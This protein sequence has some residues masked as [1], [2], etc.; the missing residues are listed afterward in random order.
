M[1]RKSTKKKK[2]ATKATKK[3][4]KKTK[5]AGLFKKLFK[6]AVVFG[7]WCAI[8]VIALV[9]WYGSEL[10]DLIKSPHFERRASIEIRGQ[11]DDLLLRY[12]EIMGASVRVEDLPSHMIY[13]LIAVEDRR[14]YL[15]HGVDPIG[16]ARAMARNLISGRI[17][18]GGSTLTQQLAK[19]LFLTHERT[20][21]RK[22]QE[23]MLAIWL[24]REFTKDEILTAYFNRVY[25]GSG[26]YGISAAARIYFDKEPKDLTLYQSALIAGLLKAPSRYSP[27]ANPELAKKRTRVVLSAMKDAGFLTETAMID[28]N[29][30]NVHI[31]TKTISSNNMRYATDWILSEAQALI[32]KTDRDLVIT[33]TLSKNIQKQA[34]ESLHNEMERIQDR[35]VT[36]GA[37][38]VTAYNGAVLAMVGGS[39]Y[40]KSQYNR[41]TQSR[42]PPGSAF[43]PVVYLTALQKGYDPDDKIEDSPITDGSYKPSNFDD[44]YLGEVTLN[45]ALS[46]SLNTAA[47]KLAN[48]VGIGNIIKTA[49]TLGIQTKLNRDLSLALG[50][51]GIPMTEMVAAYATIANDGR[52]SPPYIITTIQDEQGEIL[53]S[54]KS[55]ETGK[56][57]VKKKNARDLSRMME[58]TISIGTG[59]NAA[60]PD[61]DISRI[62]A[63]KTGTSQDYR[64]AWFIGFTDTFVAAVWLGN[65]DNSP[66][67]GITGGSSPAKIWSNVM[68]GA[69][70]EKGTM[71]LFKD[72][73]DDEGQE[74]DGGFSSFLKKLFND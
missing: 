37:V 13:A 9:A 29:E 53:Y 3:R 45:E 6:W 22:I 60:L 39:D 55:S 71:A 24:E 26:A 44:T 11:N 66:M 46:R 51:S 1:A 25:F 18:Q 30:D 57:V 7:I 23:A 19:N 41:A 65:D 62:Q 40:H 68:T 64:D 32:G 35:N 59:R 52:S 10:P 73:K 20:I 61:D 2:K 69:H 43:K 38:I 50:S 72:N 33:T 31:E 34:E 70:K 63:G 15:H 12:G 28:A 67:A 56:R 16:L 17:V 47:V 54:R 74:S 42:R 4:T 36:Q 8:A 49:R 21:K 58:Q 27:R 5:Q 48:N 14:F